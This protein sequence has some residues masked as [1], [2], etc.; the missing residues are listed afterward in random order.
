MTYL[1]SE[2]TPHIGIVAGTAE[3]AALCYRTLCHEAERFMGRHA[4]PE[5]TIHTFSLRSYFDLIDG[6][7]WPGVADL[8]SR[9]ANKLA[10]AGADFI[11]C[12]NNTLHR[13][14]DLVQSPVPWLHIAATVAAEAA[15]RGFHRVGLLGTRAVM[16]DSMYSRHLNKE[17]IELIIPLADERDNI[18]RII[19]HEL[20]AGRFTSHTRN[21]LRA[22]IN[23]FR[24]SGCDAVILG[25]T[26]LPLIVSSEGSPLPLLDSTRLLARAALE[27]VECRQT[28]DDHIE[29]SEHRNMVGMAT[30]RF[31]LV[32]SDHS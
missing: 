21:V 11:I 18:Q 24:T 1:T 13:A 10:H 27:Q 15:R 14:Y 25:C 17:G 32:S 16:E 29:T 3:G 7:D 19:R 12:P 28:P 2:A 5:I 26:E 4:H 23:R 31:H 9:S 22:V 20:I 30:G 6:D 8:L